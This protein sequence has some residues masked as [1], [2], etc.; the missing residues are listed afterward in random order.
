MKVREVITWLEKDGWLL[1]RTR[2]AIGSTF[3]P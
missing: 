2:A 3:T 1:D